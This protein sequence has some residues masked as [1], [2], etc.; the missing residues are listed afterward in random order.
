MNTQTKPEMSVSQ[1]GNTFKVL[2][3]KGVKGAEMP[4]HFSTKEAVIIVLQ[5]EAI[6]SLTEKKIHLKAHDS[7]IIPANEIHTL[8]II[9]TL[10]ADVIMEIDS[11]IKFSEQ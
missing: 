3:V 7:A 2:H 6:L 10:Q 11:D 4:S 9:E 1:I 8:Q 5:G